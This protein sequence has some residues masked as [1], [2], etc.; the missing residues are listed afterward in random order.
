M[1]ENMCGEI[2]LNI[3]I[4]EDSLP[5]L[6]RMDTYI[7]QWKDAENEHVSVTRYTRAW[8]FL[9]EFKGQF[10][11]ILLDIMLPDKN[12]VDTAKCIRQTDQNVVIVFTT[13]MK[14]YAIN[15]Y[16]VDALDF[17]LKPISYGRFALMMKKAMIRAARATEQVL[18]RIPGSTLKMDVDSILYVE[19][20]GHSVIFHMSDDQDIKK[21]M[22]LSDVEKLLP[23]IQFSRCAVSYLINLKYVKRIE[24]DFVL[25]D[26]AKVKMTR[27]KNRE[28]R[29]AFVSYYSR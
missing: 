2:M 18:V 17:I 11:L 9:N 28:F 26:N 10:H 19:S 14:Q 3:A 5:D 16:E 23:E 20:E 7:K 13:S 29:K 15:G 22:S 4:V 25:V 24:G 12:G 27:S 21:R 6:E 8:D 1:F